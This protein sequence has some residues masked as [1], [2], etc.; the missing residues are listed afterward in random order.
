MI[1]VRQFEIDIKN[2]T[3]ALAEVCDILARLNINI[4]GVA[5]E[6][7]KGGVRVKLVT[8]DENNTREA[9]KG[10]NIE[11]REFEIISAKLPD[12]PG[13]LARLSKAMANLNIGVESIFLMHKENGFAEL[14]M[15]VDNLNE[16]RKLLE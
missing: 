1:F 3:H 15:K 11:F 6:A 9:L 16:A 14:A 7:T 10:R 12:R 5:T 2:R 4:K 13:E 8:D